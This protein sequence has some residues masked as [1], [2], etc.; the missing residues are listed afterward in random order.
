MKGKYCSCIFDDVNV[1]KSDN[2]EDSF[3]LNFSLYF[4]NEVYYAIK[5]NNLSNDTFL[6]CMLAS[7]GIWHSL[8]IITTFNLDDMIS[9]E[10]NQDVIEKICTNSLL[11]MF[12]AYDGEGYI[13]WEKNEQT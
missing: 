3:S 9:K 10:L 11:V 7:D 6:K 4:K 12:G 2:F 5:R 1:N 8:C 13:F